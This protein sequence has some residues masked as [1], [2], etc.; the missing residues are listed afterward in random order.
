LYKKVI[1]CRKC[2]GK[3]AEKREQRAAGEEQRAESREQ[4]A[5]S[6][7]QRA[8]SREQGEER[9]EK[10]AESREQRAETLRAQSSIAISSK[11]CRPSSRALLG[12]QMHEEQRAESREQRAESGEQR[13]E[14]KE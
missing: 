5:G 8:E 12:E 2:R 6:R 4:G 13:A 11:I 10:R 3:K 1:S 9:R 7:E 14:S